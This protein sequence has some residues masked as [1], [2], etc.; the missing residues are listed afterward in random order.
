M[1]CHALVADGQKEEAR[2]VL[3]EVLA[4]AG[5][6]YVKPYFVAQAYAALGEIE[7]AFECFEKA[8]EG[9]D[10]WMIW[11]GTDIKLDALRQDPRYYEILR[12]TNNPIIDRQFPDRA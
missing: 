9:R 12:K 7:L 2:R 11:F 5:K 4:L 1:L 3:D 10:D 6:S 8:V